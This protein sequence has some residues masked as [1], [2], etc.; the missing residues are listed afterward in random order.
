MNKET[1]HDPLKG[2]DLQLNPEGFYNLHVTYDRCTSL[3][4][5][6]GMNKS[7]I[8]E[9]VIEENQYLRQ[10]TV[11]SADQEGN[12]SQDEGER[13]CTDPMSSDDEETETD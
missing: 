10:V 8:D 4:E 7:D 5:G 6:C 3:A 12:D 2:I 1:D 13:V 9:T 11:N